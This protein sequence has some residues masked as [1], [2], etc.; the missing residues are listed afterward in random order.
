VEIKRYVVYDTRLGLCVSVRSL[1]SA[2]IGAAQMNQVAGYARFV[3][4]IVS[5]VR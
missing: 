1:E 4:R 3:A 2:E 5:E